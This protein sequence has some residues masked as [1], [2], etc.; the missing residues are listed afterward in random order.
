MKKQFLFVLAGAL[1]LMLYVPA[2]QAGTVSVASTYA[3]S[4]YDTAVD[5][6]DDGLPVSLSFTQAKGSFGAQRLDISAEFYPSDVDCRTG[7]SI[8]GGLVYSASVTTYADHSQNFGFSD[9]GWICVHPETGHY[10][11]EVYG[12]YG[13]GTGRF[14]GASGEWIST[15]EG[16]NLEP[17]GL[18]PVGFRTVV[19]TV[20]GTMVLP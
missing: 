5:N 3:G 9:S 7:Y 2:S 1:A 10:Y 6:F 16:N 18:E 12:V 13:G 15:F 17:A 20:K 4:G 14:E 11:G 8:E 19:G